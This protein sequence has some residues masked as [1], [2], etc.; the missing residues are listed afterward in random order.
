ML[1][2]KKKKKERHRNLASKFFKVGDA[3]RL[4]KYPATIHPDFKEQFPKVKRQQT[5]SYVKLFKG[6]FL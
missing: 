2:E 3:I 4:G 6:H 1:C 5:I